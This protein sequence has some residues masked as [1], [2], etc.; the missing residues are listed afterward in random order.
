MS[1]RESSP[2]PPPGTSAAG[3][4]QPR[5][6]SK[7][8]RLEDNRQ[9]L[10]AL[11]REDYLHI[12]KDEEDAE[13]AA[14]DNLDRFWE[15]REAHPNTLEEL[16]VALD[17][18]RELLKTVGS[19]LDQLDPLIEGLRETSTPVAAQIRP[20]R[21][22]AEMAKQTMGEW[23]DDEI[24]NLAVLSASS[25][26][27]PSL[28]TEP[29]KAMV[30]ELQ[31]EK[32]HVSARVATALQE[33]AEVLAPPS[34]A[35]TATVATEASKKPFARDFP[36]DRHIRKIFTGDADT[37]LADYHTWRDLWK[38]VAKQVEDT[39]QEADPA[40]M[41]H[42][43]R[44]SIG[45]TAAKITTS[46]LSVEAVLKILEDKYDDIVALMES[47]VPKPRAPGDGRSAADMTAEAMAFADRWPRM[48]E[49]LAAHDIE[50]DTFN[51]VRVQLAA[52]GPAAAKKWRIYLKSTM[53]E[54]PEKAKMG[55]AY[56]WKTFRKWL[57]KIQDEVD[58]K[59]DTQDD[60]GSSAGLFSFAT[61]GAGLSSE[62]SSTPIKGC[63]SCGPSVSHAS[64]S[65]S[66]IANMES[67]EFFKLCQDNAA[68]KKCC[69]ATWS[70]GHGKSCTTKCNK[71]N[72]GHLSSRHKYAAAMTGKRSA[73]K[74]SNLPA[75]KR[76]RAEP[77]R[78]RRDSSK[79]TLS[80]EE[81]RTAVDMEI[82][83]REA[84]S[85]F[86]VP[87]SSTSVPKKGAW[88]G[89]LS[90]GK[91]GKFRGGARGGKGAASKQDPPEKK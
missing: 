48:R 82:A 31:K 84:R 45:G 5:P 36:V 4:P 86:V 89:G 6:R 2:P 70:P 22:L 27:R 40:A 79:A 56:N 25:F 49:E 81:F 90:K 67:D 76:S 46:A 60:E 1:D 44:A 7:A 88:R 11:L 50:F 30:A 61:A 68:C 17:E 78:E 20:A 51:G 64:S 66:K 18:G 13:E 3:S 12:L 85:G 29:G 91:R 53:R 23:K 69:Q 62:R 42:L 33:L 43:L 28:R 72:R 57:Q 21:L 55:E 10:L 74:G 38:H 15:L 37:A 54:L 8:Q 52:F 77:S 34:A 32:T 26:Y 39:C 87:S 73:D 63:L 80:D 9:A 41:L 75:A 16:Q 58:N 14:Q 83:A 24:K 35:T 65:C 59:T 71:C 47:Y 19:Y